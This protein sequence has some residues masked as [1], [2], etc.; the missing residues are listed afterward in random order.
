MKFTFRIAFTSL[1]ILIQGC[2]LAQSEYIIRFEGNISKLKEVLDAQGDFEIKDHIIYT[3]IY[4]LSDKLRRLTD[5]RRIISSISSQI[6]GIT[7]SKP[8][9]IRSKEPNDPFYKDQW[10]YDIL[11]AS[12]A[13]EYGTGGVTCQGDTIVM[14][15]LDSGFDPKHEDIAPNVWVNHSEIPGDGIDNDKNGY[16]DDVIGLNSATDNDKHFLDSHGLKVSGILGARG[17]NS[18]GVCGVNWNSKVMLVSYIPDDFYVLKGLHYI[19]T[20]RRKYNQ[21]NGKEGAFVV[22]VNCSFGISNEFPEDGHEMWCN[23]Y[24]SLGMQGIIS[25]GATANSN[26]N[27]D[28]VGDIPST[29]ASPYLIVVTNTDK[30]DKK[31]TNAGYGVNS[32]D[33]GAPGEGAFNV[34]LNNGYTTFSGTSASTP[35][36]AGA[37]GLLY[38]T[39]CCSLI[40]EAKINP[41][42][43]CLKIRDYILNGATAIATLK[44]VTKTEARLS[45]SG[46]MNKLIENCGNATGKNN[47]DQITLNDFGNQIKF[48]FTGNTYKKYQITIYNIL[49]S[50]LTTSSAE[51]QPYSSNEYILDIS[52]LPPAIYILTVWDEN[53]PV[54]K[55]FVKLK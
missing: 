37:V 41:A 50:A 12:E 24:D 31:V 49:G 53:E 42:Q 22:S 54:S 6:Y 26:K 44:S 5:E 30:N 21:S 35:H 17:N 13:W 29:C 48:Q 39:A 14:A 3:N 7:L 23:M 20:Q 34:G 15:V 47:I 55:Q 32:V 10:Q 11:K 18:N 45:L 43:T 33:I 4:L 19:L 28:V 38:S 40:D 36:V 9:E 1:S 8:V 52:T 46:A 27:V 25:V 16:I 2:L 51:F